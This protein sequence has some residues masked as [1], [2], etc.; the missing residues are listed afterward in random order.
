MNKKKIF[1]KRFDRIETAYELQTESPID[2]MDE[3]FWGLHAES[4][5]VTPHTIFCLSKLLFNAVQAQRIDHIQTILRCKNFRPDVIVKLVEW[6]AASENERISMMEEELK[7]AATFIN[8]FKEGLKSRA[9]Q[10]DKRTFI[11]W[12]LENNIEPENIV[13]L[14]QMIVDQRVNMFSY[15]NKVIRAW[16]R[17][18]KPDVI[19]RS[20]RLPKPER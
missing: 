14:K 5:R 13:E 10:V 1:D 17:E 2:P 3:R 18:A 15:G 4:R 8:K 11:A 20:G 12:V 7:Y 19:F 6:S 9:D 16:Y